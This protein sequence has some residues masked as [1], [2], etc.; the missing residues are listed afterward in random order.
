MTLPRTVGVVGVGL[1]GGSLVR[2]LRAVDA[3]PR[4]VAVDPSDHVRA[5]LV[6]EGLADDVASSVEASPLDACDLVVLAAPIASILESIGAVSARMRDGAVLT[7]VAGVKMPVVAAARSSVRSGVPFVGAH[8]MF[9]GDHGGFDASSAERWRDGIVAVCDDDVEPESVA[10]VVALHRAL[11]ADVVV[12]SADAH[13]AAIAAVSHLP[14][15]VA[16]ALSLLG[17]D[18]GALARRLAG[19]GFF[20]ATRLARFSWDVQGE[21]ARRNP[22]VR[23]AAARLRERLDACLAALDDAEAARALFDRARVV[24]EGFE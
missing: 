18:A 24:R 16:S 7:D 14:Y 19:R 11:G 20:D 6:A 1:V 4:I 3:P 13:D 12:C 5:R 22:H 10:R 9:G 17:E 21:V 2:A 15:V 8:P 23:A